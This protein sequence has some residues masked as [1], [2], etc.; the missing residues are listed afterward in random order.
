M[1]ERAKRIENAIQ[2]LELQV[3]DDS[4]LDKLEI[5]NILLDILD[6]PDC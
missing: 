2:E 4:P 1:D 3:N 5:S 6:Y